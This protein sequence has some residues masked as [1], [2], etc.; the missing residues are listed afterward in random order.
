MCIE[1][2]KKIEMTQNNI[3]PRNVLSPLIWTTRRSSTNFRIILPSKFL[4]SIYLKN[5]VSR[6]E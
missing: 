2:N 5:K 3:F 6:D 4:S 1:Y